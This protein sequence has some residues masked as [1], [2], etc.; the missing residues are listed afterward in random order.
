MPN[1]EGG[2]QGR[3]RTTDTVIFSHVLYQ[4]SY[5]GNP[6]ARSGRRGFI[7][8]EVLPVQPRA[9]GACRGPRGRVGDTREHIGKVRLTDAEL[10]NRLLREMALAR[11][12]T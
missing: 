10:E 4:L 9:G 1:G 3:N 5:L 6:L 2:A 11:L 8:A 7:G 12:A